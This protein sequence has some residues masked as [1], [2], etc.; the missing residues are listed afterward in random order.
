M[1]DF[2][3]FLFYLQISSSSWLKF[4][5]KRLNFNLKKVRDMPKFKV[6]KIEH[7]NHRRYGHILH[8]LI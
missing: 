7:K 3:T 8:S 1:N 6:D 4:I 5:F 2:H